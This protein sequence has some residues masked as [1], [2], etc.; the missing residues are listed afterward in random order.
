MGGGRGRAR[1]SGGG[2]AGRQPSIGR[3]HL[4]AA[5]LMSATVCSYL[6]LRKKMGGGWGFRW[7]H[8]CPWPQPAACFAPLTARRSRAAGTPCP[9]A[10]P[11]K[12]G[13]RPRWLDEG[14]CEG[15]HGSARGGSLVRPSLR[16][17]TALPPA[18]LV[19]RLAVCRQW[20][21]RLTHQLEAQRLHV[22]GCEARRLGLQ[23][24]PEQPR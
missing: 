6:I 17:P 1:T 9:A 19:G 21:A 13:C 11:R 10:P 14:Q 5:C 18:A 24:L 4:A 22:W 20:P 3:A 2:W 7:P 12:S 8:A 15:G 16:V 23:A